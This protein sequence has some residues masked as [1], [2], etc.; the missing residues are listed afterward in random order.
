MKKQILIVYN[1]Q[2]QNVVSVVKDLIN[3]LNK[4]FSKEI[5]VVVCSSEKLTWKIC[6]GDLIITLGGDGTIL[7]VS[8]YAIE[9]NIPVA[10]I[11]LGGLGYLAEFKVED[12][13]YIVRSFLKENI[14]LQKRI[15]L[16][17]TYKNRKHYA[18]NDCVIKPLSSK[19]CSIELF[20]NNQKITEIVGD[21]IIIS[22]P[23]GST[24][25]SLASGGS[26]VEP[27]AEVILITPIS[28]HMLSIRPIIISVKKI[29]KLKIPRYKSN[30]NLLLSLDGQRNFIVKPEDEVIISSSEKKL[31]FVPNTAENFF[32]ILRQKLSW[33]KR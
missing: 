13:V 15:V 10:G 17:V 5:K 28:P 9:K 2:K 29:V 20:I 24:A 22:T 12:V 4:I 14:P 6:N 33:G 11:N 26:I 30:K 18:V 1:P 23:T 8:P 16:N 31:L 3:K 27:D 21:G 19:V 25:Y 32:K 7:R